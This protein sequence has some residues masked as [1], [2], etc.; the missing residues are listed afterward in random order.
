[1]RYVFTPDAKPGYLIFDLIFFFG[2]AAFSGFMLAH[3][4]LLA[5]VR[6]QITYYFDRN[7]RMI[8]MED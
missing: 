3:L 4:G 8:R 5:P 1:L 2:M 6:G 7:G